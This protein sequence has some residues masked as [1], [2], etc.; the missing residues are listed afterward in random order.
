MIPTFY[1]DP[2]HV[3]S[4]VSREGHQCSLLEQYQGTFVSEE[5][6]AKVLFIQRGHGRPSP[7]DCSYKAEK[8][9]VRSL[10]AWKMDVGSVR[11]QEGRQ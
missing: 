4:A 8:E 2:Y 6:T 9:I 7:L 10:M 3:S 5:A 1:R 11:S